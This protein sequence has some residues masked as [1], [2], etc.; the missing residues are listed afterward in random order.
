MKKYDK[1]K[2]IP[3]IIDLMNKGMSIH[4]I[5]KLEDMPSDDTIYSWI[6]NR[7]KKSRMSEEEKRMIVELYHQGKNTVEIAEILGRNDTT[8][9]DY[10]RSVNLKP[11][12]VRIYFSDSDKEKI[13]KMYEDGLSTEKIGEV[14]KVTG[15]TIAKIL[16]DSGVELRGLGRITKIIHHDYFETI[17]NEYKAYFLGLMITDGSVVVPK[18]RKRSPSISLEL[19]AQDKYIVELFEKEICGDSNTT[20]INKAGN[21]AFRGASRKMAED[22]AKYGVVPNKTFKTYL[23][24][25]ENSLMRHL[26]RGIFDGDGTVY[27][28][29]VDGH[30]IFGFYGTNTL[31]NQLKDYLIKEINISDNKIIDKKDCNVSMVYFSKKEDAKAFYDLIY[32]D[33]TIYLKRKKDKFDSVI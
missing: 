31:L 29:K 7:P 22:L 1:E 6:K 15:N 23:P 27:T 9:G 25:I 11:R 10:L 5:S 16:R 4:Q 28:R 19:Q 24:K 20:K 8:I 30:L 17:D 2:L 13:I 14:F 21:A 26:I 32:S 33:A 12:N 3:I 18:T